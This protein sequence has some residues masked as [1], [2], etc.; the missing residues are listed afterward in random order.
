MNL[1]LICI[2]FTMQQITLI[3]LPNVI[4]QSLIGSKSN[5]SLLLICV[6]SSGQ[7]INRTAFIQYCNSPNKICTA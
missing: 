6:K 2:N 5:A 3:Y 4:F 1:T 7:Y